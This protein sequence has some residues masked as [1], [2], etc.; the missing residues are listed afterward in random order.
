LERHEPFVNNLLATSAL[1]MM[2]RLVRYG[3]LNH[4]GAFYNAESGDPSPSPLIQSY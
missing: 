4:Q 2:T 3:E 1:S